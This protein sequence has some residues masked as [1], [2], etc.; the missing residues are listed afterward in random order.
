MHDIAY[1]T[2]YIKLIWRNFKV[3]KKMED[4]M[5]NQILGLEEY[6]DVFKALSDL[7]RLKMMWLL[8]SIDSKISVSEMVEVLRINQYNA[9]KHLK[10]LKKADMIYRKKDGRWRYY[11][12]LNKDTIFHKHIKNAVMSIPKELV[13]EEIQRCKQCLSIR[14]EDGCIIDDETKKANKYS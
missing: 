3:N 2:I 11:Y 13:E 5:K 6:I 4:K 8:Y 14:G 7:T 10:I 1:I 12:Y 9:S